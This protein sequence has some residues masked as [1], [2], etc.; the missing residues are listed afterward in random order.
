MCGSNFASVLAQ[1]NGLA[2]TPE[3]FDVHL[4]SIDSSLPSFS[5]STLKP[6]SF[7]PFLCD[8]VAQA[9]TEEAHTPLKAD[10]DKEL[11]RPQISSPRYLPVA[12]TPSHEAV[13]VSTVIPSS[14]NAVI[15]KEKD[16]V[17]I[18]QHETT[19]SLDFCDNYN[20]M[21]KKTAS[22]GPTCM[23]SCTNLE[24]KKK[25]KKSKMNNSTTRA[26]Y[27]MSEKAESLI[28]P[29]YVQSKEKLLS[30]KK[31]KR[32]KV[33]PS[34]EKKGAKYTP[35]PGNR[36][37]VKHDYVDY[38]GS[39]FE[40]NTLP[41]PRSSKA[42]ALKTKR[43]NFTE[44]LH[45]MLE[46]VEVQ[47][48]PNDEP[49]PPSSIDG[50]TPPAVPGKMCSSIISWQPHGRCF[51]VHSPDRFVKSILPQFFDQS[52][53]T[54]FQRQLNLYGFRRITNRASPDVG[55]YYHELFLRYR[56]DLCYNMVRVKVKGTGCKAAQSPETEPNFYKMNPIV[57][58]VIQNQCFKDVPIVNSKVDSDIPQVHET[59]SY[60]DAF[61][62]ELPIREVCVKPENEPGKMNGGHCPD[63]EIASGKFISGCFTEDIMQKVP[64]LSIPTCL[65]S[66]CDFNISKEHSFGVEPYS[67]NEHLGE[68][69]TVHPLDKFSFFPKNST[70]ETQDFST[71]DTFVSTEVG[72]IFNSEDSDG[73]LFNS[74]LGN[75][76]Y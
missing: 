37:R 69:E 51:V 1:P 50:T 56:I 47:M 54:S 34:I 4:Q 25:R 14:P 48:C 5:W 32:K 57:L 42:K 63:R 62:N 65:L 36:L 10:A 9:I 21:K 35:K 60:L 26:S 22:N 64:S 18:E 31:S 53:L 41:P 30:D 52:K 24:S 20:N 70:I 12:E 27:Q 29:C 15:L 19:E 58:S 76:Y 66:Y 44:K 33:D 67:S 49:P 28:K 11:S 46:Q 7:E 2:C 74:L 6:A 71:S 8:S 16:A 59:S 38:S 23:D 75:E 43:L 68:A 17:L 72:S 61:K 39:S 3:E 55:A 73:L 40:S 13:I 45:L